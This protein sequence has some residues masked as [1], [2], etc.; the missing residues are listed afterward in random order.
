MWMGCAAEGRRDTASLVA[1]VCAGPVAAG[2]A[3][4]ML[5]SMIC[6]SIGTIGPAREAVTKSNEVEQ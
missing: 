4:F 2:V 5:H 3:P 6:H 1:A